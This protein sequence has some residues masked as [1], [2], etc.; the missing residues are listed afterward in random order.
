MKCETDHDKTNDLV[1]Y[2]DGAKK[3]ERNHI[4][5]MQV[6]KANTAPPRTKD[7]SCQQMIQVYQHRRQQYKPVFFPVV[8]IIPVGNCPYKNKMKEIVDESLEQGLKFID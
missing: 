5:R 4:F 8:L 1:F 7:R 6:V 3:V 2:E